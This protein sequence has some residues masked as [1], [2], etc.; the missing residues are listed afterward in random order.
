MGRVRDK[1][2]QVGEKK[3]RAPNFSPEEI[4]YLLD[5][6]LRKDYADIVLSK[7]SDAYSKKEKQETWNG[8]A[9]EF[10]AQCDMSV[11][12]FTPSVC[13]IRMNSGDINATAAV[14]FF[15]MRQTD[16]MQSPAKSAML[17]CIDPSA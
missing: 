8:I 4:D 15:K 12:F 11:V 9:V 7:N 2:P 16:E 13:G 1:K 14:T 10:D 6:V 17:T 5:T 3:E